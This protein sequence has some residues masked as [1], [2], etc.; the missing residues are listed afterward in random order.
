M[1][2]V[3]MSALLLVGF[4]STGGVFCYVLFVCLLS[5]PFAFCPARLFSCFVCFANM[6]ALRLRP[7]LI[8]HWLYWWCRCFELKPR[9]WCFCCFFI[10]DKIAEAQTPRQT[11]NEA[12]AQK[13]DEDRQV[14]QRLEAVETTVP[15]SPAQI[16]DQEVPCQSRALGC[17]RQGFRRRFHHAIP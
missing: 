6:Y 13:V 11:R 15:G 1:L 7:I 14:R 3:S 17:L 2:P 9:I 5:R 8:A 4:S 10:F 16:G 12:T